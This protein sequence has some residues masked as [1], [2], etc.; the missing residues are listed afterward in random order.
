MESPLA[1]SLSVLAR[2]AAAFAVAVFAV[3]AASTVAID[4][5]PVVGTG[6]PNAC[7]P[8]STG[9]FG[10]VADTYYIS[11]YETTNAQYAEFL[12]AVASTDTNAL[13]NARMNTSTSGGITQSGSSGSFGYTTKIGFANKPVTFVNFYDSLR[14]ANWLHNGQPTGAQGNATTED[15]AYTI[16]SAGI[17][18]NSITRNAGATV[19]LTSED[20]WYK[21]AYYDAVS[22]SYFNYPAG[23]NAQTTCT[24]PSAAANSAN[25]QMQVGNVT[26]VGSY[27]G[28]S[29]PNGTFDQ[30]GNVWEWN[31]AIIPATLRGLRGGRWLDTPTLLAASFR[32][33]TIWTVEE[34][35]VGFRVASLVPEPGT[36]LLVLTGLLG[37]ATRRKR[38]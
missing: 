18:A 9:C 23:S 19:F 32:G 5:V 2:L 13:Y 21:A 3:P 12:N 14:F 36:G 17:A 34:I 31:E 25:C 1:R 37:L 30:G 26:D 22:T 33:A 8:Q 27:T 20:E 4:W 29:S 7:D 38:A 11:K 24:A 6:T 15:G 28:S 10:A 16:T 35:D